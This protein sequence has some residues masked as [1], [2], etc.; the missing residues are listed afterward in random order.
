MTEPIA[1]LRVENEPRYYVLYLDLNGHYGMRVADEP[2]GDGESLALVPGPRKET[3]SYSRDW[4]YKLAGM[5]GEDIFLY[6]EVPTPENEL[7]L[8]LHSPELERL[9]LLLRDAIK[10]GGPLYPH[11]CDG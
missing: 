10:A 5:I 11:L 8:F 1:S 7:R 4:H 6:R 9:A 2:P 3:A